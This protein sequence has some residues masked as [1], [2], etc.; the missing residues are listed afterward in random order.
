[1]D[2]LLGGPGLRRGR[3]HTERLSVGDALDFWRVSAV[4][5]PDHLTLNAEMILPGKATLEFHIPPM[6]QLTSDS[7]RPSTKLTQ[8]ARFRPTGLMGLLYW[9][10]VLPLHHIVFS[11]ML[12]GICNEAQ[13]QSTS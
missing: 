2:K 6:D 4:Q 3:R 13:T 7:S 5:A 9:Y 12:K 8:T 10:A 11:G 1:M